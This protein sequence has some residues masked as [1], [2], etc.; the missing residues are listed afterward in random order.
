MIASL[1]AKQ[2]AELFLMILLGFILVK[3]KLLTEKDS[4]VIST[5]VLYA[6]NPCLI[7]NAF[8]IE[9]SIQIRNGLILSFIAAILIHLI[10][11]ILAQVFGK[12]FSLE[13]IEKASIIYTNAGNLI[14]PLVMAILGKE[15]VVYTTGYIIVTTFFIWTHGRMLICEQKEFDLKNI[16]QNINVIASFI[17]ILMFLF[18]ISL[19][20]L[21]TETM[22][23]L[24]VTIGPLSM[25]V[26][27]MLIGGMDV[28]SFLTNKRVYGVTFL[29]MIV[30]PLV[31]TFILK[32]S[33]ASRFVANGDMILL[34][35]LLASIAPTA[36][37]VTQ[38]AQ[39]Y[40]RNSEY[41]SA[42]YFLTTLLCIVTMPIFVWIYQ[43]F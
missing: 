37:S 27:G 39:V 10:F 15:W 30:F 12:F 29:K 33:N 22:D 5:V 13:S 43:A 41:A 2:I 9:Y 28:K 26:A 6:I 25:I 32:C 35:T 24:T 23:S 17:G 42:Y 34:I 38:I 11:I 1:L 16:F 8:Q 14:I 18:H 36:A 19:P 4:K 3:C 21:L 31:I 20:S 7:I 40:N